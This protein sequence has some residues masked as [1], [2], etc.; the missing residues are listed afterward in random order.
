MQQD[1]HEEQVTIHTWQYKF[2]INDFILSKFC[3]FLCFK[4]MSPIENRD[5]CIFG[6]CILWA[7]PK[8]KHNVEN[9][10]TALYAIQDVRSRDISH[11]RT[12]VTIILSQSLVWGKN[13][14]LEGSGTKIARNMGRF[15]WH[16]CVFFLNKSPIRKSQLQ[17]VT[18]QI[19]NENKN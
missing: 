5:L 13:Q 15:S 3:K 19:S 14:K 18:Y 7:M 10:G 16:G 4:I 2:N 11:L 1:T 17:E 12:Q 6:S 8:R 9:A